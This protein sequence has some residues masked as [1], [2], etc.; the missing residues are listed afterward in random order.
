MAIL[1]LNGCQTSKE[2]TDALITQSIE[3]TDASITESIYYVAEQQAERITGLINGDLR[4]LK[5]LSNIMGDY[6]NIPAEQRRD[7]FDDMLY[8]VVANEENIGSL[9]MCWKPN[10]LDGMDS[11]YIGRPGSSPTGQ[12]VITCGRETGYILRYGLSPEKIEKIM[13]TINGFKADWQIYVDNPTPLIVFGRNTYGINMMIPIVN[14]RSREIV[15]A[16]GFNL[17]VKVIQSVIEKTVKSFNVHENIIAM[18]VYSSNGTTIGSIF[19]ERIGKILSDEDIPL[20]GDNI[21]PAYNAV[22]EGKYYNFK[23]F[24]PIFRE[25]VE[26][27]MVPFS[28]G[29]DIGYRHDT[30]WTVMIVSMAELWIKK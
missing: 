24:T 26:I 23:S 17:D 27:V 21:L 29:I 18:A 16:V 9:Y 20:Y 13:A 12:Y 19:P 8:R 2:R 15:G 1:F 14:S 10:V 5:T 4:I 28:I 11:H 6:E 30:T 22:L 7:W 25:N 3:L